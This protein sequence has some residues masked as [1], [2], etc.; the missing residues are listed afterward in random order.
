MACTHPYIINGRVVSCGKCISC[1]KKRI[2]DW[3]VRLVL[4]SKYF[5]GLSTYITLTYNDA[6]LPA[7]GVLFKE[8]YQNFFKRLRKQLDLHYNSRKIRYFLCGEYG[9]Q[10]SRPHYH[11]ILFGLPFTPEIYQLILK[12]WGKGFIYFKPFDFHNARY[13][14]KYCVKQFVKSKSYSYID[15]LTGEY[16]DKLVPEFVTMSRRCG[17]G[18]KYLFDH[19]LEFMTSNIVQIGK[20]GYSIPTSFRQKL[21]KQ[22][23]RK[24]DTIHIMYNERKFNKP[25]TDI[26]FDL[27][28]WLLVKHNID[29]KKYGGNV[30]IIPF[31]DYF[32]GLERNLSRETSWCRSHHIDD[33]FFYARKFDYRF[34]DVMEQKYM[35]YCGVKSSYDYFCSLK[36]VVYNDF[37]YFF[38]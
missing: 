6:N 18:Y 29:I 26:P 21:R 17:L 35:D 16:F 7:G 2:N 22:G 23:Y 4:E 13:V 25:L 3:A 12:C 38:Y 34:P 11:L 31:C 28:V 14:A 37:E 32:D 9:E 33:R 8:D 27:K 1:R 24:Y 10:G 15:P 19:E 30:V 20:F 36:E 5:K